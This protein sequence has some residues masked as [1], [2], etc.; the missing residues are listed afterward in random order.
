MI[1][2]KQLSLIHHHKLF[3]EFVKNYKLSSSV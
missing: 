2:K 1:Y 3:L